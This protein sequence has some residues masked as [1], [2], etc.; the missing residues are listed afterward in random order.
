M[1]ASTLPGESRVAVL[2][3]CDNTTVLLR[4]DGLLSGRMLEA[5]NRP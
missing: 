3:D 4:G 5:Y 1:V 2:V